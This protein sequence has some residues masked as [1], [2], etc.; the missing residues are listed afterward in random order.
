MG[1]NGWAVF[2]LS[3]ALFDEKIVYTKYSTGVK[4]VLTTLYEIDICSS[5]TS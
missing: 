1:F 4:K 3:I 2:K 5:K